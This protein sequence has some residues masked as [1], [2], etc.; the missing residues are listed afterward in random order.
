MTRGRTEIAG[1]DRLQG[2]DDVAGGEHRIDTGFPTRAPGTAARDP[3][4]AKSAASP[5]CPRANGELSDRQSGGVVHAENTVAGKATKQPIIDHG[6][7][8]TEPLFGWLENEYRGTVEIPG[9][10]KIARSTEQHRR[11]PV[12][13]ACVHA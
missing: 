11:V 9:L 13:S 7:C 5:H 12:V 6:A 1:S 2:S 3:E 8:A 4:I 10:G